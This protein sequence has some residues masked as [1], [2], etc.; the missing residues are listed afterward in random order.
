MILTV[1]QA[2]NIS[3]TTAVD[4]TKYGKVAVDVSLSLVDCIFELLL[5]GAFHLEGEIE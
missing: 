1:F 3:S 4:T 2:I 5:N